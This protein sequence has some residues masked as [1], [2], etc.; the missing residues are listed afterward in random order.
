MF[1]NRW[2]K[3]NVMGNKS[4]S[5]R[6]WSRLSPCWSAINSR[7]GNSQEKQFPGLHTSSSI[8]SGRTV[9]TVTLLTVTRSSQE[10]VSRIALFIHLPPWMFFLNTAT[11]KDVLCPIMPTNSPGFKSYGSRIMPIS[12]VCNRPLVE[13]CTYKFLFNYIPIGA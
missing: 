9:L 12:N 10:N 13:R 4:D 8:N 7:N 3:K 11:C 1:N 2:I 5:E 6:Y